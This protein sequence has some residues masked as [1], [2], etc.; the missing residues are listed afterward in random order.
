MW[1]GSIVYKHYIGYL[2]QLVFELKQFHIID[3]PYLNAQTSDSSY[4]EEDAQSPQNLLETKQ[5]VY[6][7]MAKNEQYVKVKHPPHFYAKYWC[8]LKH[9]FF[10]AELTF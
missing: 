5:K 9:Q 8:S 4:L 6:R 1:K 3:P 2:Y 7:Y 10:M